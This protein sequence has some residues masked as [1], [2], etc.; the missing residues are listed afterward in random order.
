MQ[1]VGLIA[2]SIYW[3]TVS[4]ILYKYG[5]DSTKTISDHVATGRQKLIYTPLAIAYFLLISW[6]LYSW[7]LPAMNA[8]NYHYVLLTIGL[9]FLLLTFLIPRH[10]KNIY[11]H[12]LF[13]T[14]VGSAMFVMIA[15]LIAREVEGF[16]ALVS[17]AG[18]VGMLVAGGLLTKRG[19]RRYLQ[20]QIFYF[21]MLNMLILLL[22]YTR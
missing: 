21:A 17:A 2:I 10:G 13:A 1:H 7:F 19:R 22:T 9:V 3:V 16:V 14:I 6:F 5:Y 12:D 11:R 18:L 8:L 4:S 20:G 15:S